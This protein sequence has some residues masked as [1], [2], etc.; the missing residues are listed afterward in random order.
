MNIGYI[1]IPLLHDQRWTIFLHLCCVTTTCCEGC[2]EG[3]SSLRK[4]FLDNVNN[5]E[6]L[7][8]TFYPINKAPPV[9]VM[10]NYYHRGENKSKRCSDV[11]IEFYRDTVAR[12]YNVDHMYSISTEQYLCFWVWTDSVTYLLFPPS[13]MNTYSLLTESYFSLLSREAMLDLELPIPCD[14]FTDFEGNIYILTA[15]VSCI[16]IKYILTI[17]SFIHVVKAFCIS[18]SRQF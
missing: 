5:V 18:S 3:Y 14:N 4:E 1:Q 8:N 17:I 10:I 15:R 6:M 7:Q 16:I 13:F 11:S 12:F 2:V 9:Y